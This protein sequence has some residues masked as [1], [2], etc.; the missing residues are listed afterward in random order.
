MCDG[1]LTLQGVPDITSATLETFPQAEERSSE[2]EIESETDLS[3]PE[4]G[5]TLV[6]GDVKVKYR[7]CYG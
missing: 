5:M 3:S 7:V 4:N 2:T 1:S 6:T